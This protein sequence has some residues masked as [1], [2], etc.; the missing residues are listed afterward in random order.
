MKIRSHLRW[1]MAVGFAG[2]TAFAAV[3]FT[4]LRQIE[5]NGPLYRQ[6][7]LSKDLESDYVPPSE[8]LLQA[9]LLC[10][11]MNEASSGPQLQRYL[12]GFYNARED[13]EATYAEYMRRV[14]EGRLKTMMRGTAHTTA[15]QYFQIAQ[16]E[17]I[18]SLMQGDH[19][20]A[21]E[22]LTSR[23]MPLYEQHAEAVDL[24]VAMAQEEAHSGEL[25][26]GESVRF[27]TRAMAGVWLLLLIAGG[28]L[29][30][31]IARGI[32][33]H[34]EE[35]I[36][37]EE[38]L[39]QSNRAL[40]AVSSCNAAVV[41]ATDEKT[42]LEK[43]CSIIVRQTGYPLAWVG[44]AEK[45]EAQTVRPVAWAGA[46]GDFFDRVHVSWG[47]NR[48]GRGSMAQA[49]REG[50]PVVIDRLQEH[51]SFAV[52][53]DVLTARSFESVLAVPL[54]NGGAAFGA[55]AIYAPR[56]GSFSPGEVKLIEE[57]GND[58]AYGLV[59]LWARQERTEALAAVERARSELEERVQ[60]RTAELNVAK[61]AAESADRLKSAFLATMSHELRTP[62]NSII[63]FTGIALQ[64]LAGPLN[65]E[66]KK[67]LGMVQ[68]SAHH[69]LAL[70]NDV[71]DI[72]KIEAGQLE[73]Q[74]HPFDVRTSVEKA[75]HLLLPHAQRKGLELETEITPSVGIMVGDNRRM[76]QVLLNL[77]SNAIKFTERGGVQ[78]HCAA[79]DG[80]LVTCVRDSGAGIA[81]EEVDRL[82]QPFHQID[83]GL[84]RQ[85]EGTG[86]GLSICKKLVEL[87]GGGIAVESRLGHGS[88]FTYRLPLGGKKPS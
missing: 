24:I 30:I 14:P 82:F 62:L 43:V 11:K 13:F 73:V 25:K 35:L 60:Q 87:M 79:E 1:L 67:Q 41:H 72:S 10:N 27:Y 15:E 63:G 8:S 78:V 16:Q 59:S 37:S 84:A 64:E 40:R 55:L 2:I 86:L 76:E 28:V 70:I 18:P 4:A 42:L 9:A 56:T 7:S 34:T 80:W 22:V 17:F 26:A 51:P 3:A 29:S 85:H 46:V 44:Y 58:L 50:A 65:P 45:D 5:V 21:R 52:W 53:K 61:E 69:L 71:L 39:S 20:K 54:K 48:Y 81:S 57:L 49:I 33:R 66:Q 12:Q 88:T 75:V 31:A 19:K 23:M 83:T 47:D 38:A 68:K 6:I 36:R 74:M 32:A 77:L